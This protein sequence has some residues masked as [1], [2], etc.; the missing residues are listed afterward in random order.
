LSDWWRR[1]KG[2]GEMDE[3]S[4]AFFVCSFYCSRHSFFM[5]NE[6]ELSDYKGSDMNLTVTVAGYELNINYLTS[7]HARSIN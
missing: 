1:C 3:H 7:I 6:G 4:D 5:M 2:H